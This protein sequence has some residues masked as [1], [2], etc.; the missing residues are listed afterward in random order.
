[1]G[2][3][4]RQ[5]GLLPKGKSRKKTLDLIVKD[6]QKRIKKSERIQKRTRGVEG[7]HMWF[8][9]RA[10][11]GRAQS[12][13]DAL[14]WPAGSNERKHMLSK[15]KDNFSRKVERVNPYGKNTRKK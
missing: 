7:V 8:A 14:S 11:L 1:M 12:L 2:L 10:R 9:S 3:F 5:R 6:A 15:A 13:S 4:R